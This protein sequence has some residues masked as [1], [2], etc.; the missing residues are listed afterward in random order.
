MRVEENVGITGYVRRY[1]SSLGP[2]WGTLIIVVIVFSA[3]NSLTNFLQFMP[4][5]VP[6]ALTLVLLIIVIVIAIVLIILRSEEEYIKYRYLKGRGILMLG[7]LRDVALRVRSLLAMLNTIAEKVPDYTTVLK[8][9]GMDV[10]KSFAKDFQEILDSAPKLRNKT[11][12]FS[13]KFQRWLKY[14]SKAGMGKFEGH[15][16]QNHEGTITVENSFLTYERS[17]G[18]DL[19]LCDFMAGYIEGMLRELSGCRNIEVTHPGGS[20]SSEPQCGLLKKDPEICLFKV[21]RT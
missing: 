18:D 1:Y 7:R 16:D 20:S 10:G 13:D 4:F 6:K 11:L 5:G 8:A 3:I 9:T 15:L 12:P 14:D 17:A 2:F 21:R 19:P